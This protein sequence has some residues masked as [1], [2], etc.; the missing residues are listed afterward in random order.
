MNLTR[1]LDVALPD[2]PARTVAARYP[3]MDP[4]T[5]H[6]EH[7]ED[8]K[9]VV[10]VYVP[11]VGSMFKLTPQQWQIAQLF[12]GKRSYEEVAEEYSQQI[13]SEYAASDVQDFAAELECR[14]VLVQNAAGKKHSVPAAE[15]RGTAEKEQDPQQMGGPVDGHF[16]GVQP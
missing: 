15:H 10:R 14:G 3:R 5:T 4:G 2:I 6:R 16:P 7:L 11:C 12:D 8:G 1:A 13:G 9:L